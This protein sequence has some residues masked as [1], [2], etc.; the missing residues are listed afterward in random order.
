MKISLFRF[1][2]QRLVTMIFKKI[3]LMMLKNNCELKLNFCTSLIWKFSMK[4]LNGITIIDIVF[5]F[6]IIVTQ[7]EIIVE[8]KNF[9][10][11]YL[12]E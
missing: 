7:K 5:F 6:I 3:I 2:Y 11:I 12:Y 10:W 1:R 4:F 8:T 9:Y